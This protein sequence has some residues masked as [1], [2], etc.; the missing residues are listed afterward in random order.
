MTLKK[1]A[2][3]GCT[4]PKTNIEPENPWLEDETSFWNGP[5]SGDMLIFSGRGG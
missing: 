1:S 3:D 2:P 5:F 4:P